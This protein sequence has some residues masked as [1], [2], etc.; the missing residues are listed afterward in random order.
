MPS[1]HYTC[2]FFHYGNI[3][4]FKISFTAWSEILLPSTS[5]P[6][7]TYNFIGSLR[8]P[9]RDESV[10]MESSQW[11]FI[12]LY[13]LFYLCLWTQTKNRP[14]CFCTYPGS[15]DLIVVERQSEVFKSFQ[16]SNDSGSPVKKPV[17]EEKA[18]TSSAYGPNDYC[19]VEETYTTSWGPDRIF[20]L[21]PSSGHIPTIPLTLNFWRK[22]SPNPL[23][24]PAHC[25]G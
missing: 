23:N 3:D 11:S 2:R 7:Q 8:R 9:R 12:G 1:C 24:K 22:S 17:M 25:S 21:N 6:S 14:S 4:N 16:V 10:A 13:H 19:L 18:Q 15:H 5:I 20:I